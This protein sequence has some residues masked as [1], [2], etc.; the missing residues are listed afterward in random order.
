MNA[1]W[2]WRKSSRSASGACVEVG[3][4][5]G[6]VSIGVRDSKLGEG[7]PVLRFGR[8]EFAAFIDGLHR[9]GR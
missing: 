1:N 9:S 4:R 5:P 8:R 2:A 6:E 3:T 7:S